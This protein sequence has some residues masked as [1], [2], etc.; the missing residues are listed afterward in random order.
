MNLINIC[1]ELKSNAYPG[2]GIIIGRS[3]DG[4]HA[5]LIYFITGRSESSRN[6]IFVPEEDGIRTEAFDPSKLN[7][8]SLFIY[9]PVRIYDGHLIVTN[10]DQTDTIRDN[11]L[12]DNSFHSAL[13]KREF[14]PDANYT[15]RISGLILPDGSYK[16][17]ILKS[18]DGDPACCCRSFFEYDTAIAGAGHFISTYKCDG[19]PTP[20]FEGEP[21]LISVTGNLSEFATGIWNALNADN[22][23]SLYG[24]SKDIHS[25]TNE[26]ILFNKY[27]K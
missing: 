5:V 9:H 1:D 13:I 24:L 22:K 11:M 25:G 3:E 7:D 4:K 15:P 20:S 14:E 10:G 8:P 21:K 6:R 17:S 19:N 2:R 12:A 16:L 27:S 26:S 23:V 18:L